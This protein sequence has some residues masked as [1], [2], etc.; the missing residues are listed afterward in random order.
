MGYRYT[1][2]LCARALL[3]LRDRERATSYVVGL[4]QASE[5]PPVPQ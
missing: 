2:I 5:T 4:Q 3:T 1:D